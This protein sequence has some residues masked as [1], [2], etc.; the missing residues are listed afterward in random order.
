MA[1]DD[2]T[3]PED[4]SDTEAPDKSGEAVNDPLTRSD[5]EA[6]RAEFDARTPEE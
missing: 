1:N 5:V 4:E 3:K 6:P 2:K